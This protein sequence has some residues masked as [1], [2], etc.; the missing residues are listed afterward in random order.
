V[1][2]QA[3]H[4]VGEVDPGL[5]L[6]EISVSSTRGAAGDVPKLTRQQRAAATTYTN[7]RT[8]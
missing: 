3:E 8:T 6:E 4:A 1:A 5:V 7:D 2:G